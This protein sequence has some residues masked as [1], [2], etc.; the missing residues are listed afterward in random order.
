MTQALYAHMNNKTIK[1][2][3]I[4]KKIREVHKGKTTVIY[5]EYLAVKADL[6]L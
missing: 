5:K 6:L 4:N 2:L 3:K 1:K